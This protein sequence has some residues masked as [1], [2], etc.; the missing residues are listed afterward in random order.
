M[1]DWSLA[2]RNLLRNRR[3]TASTLAALA[4]GLLAILL[5]RGFETNLANTMYTTFVRGGGHMQIQHRDYYLFGSG[6]P[7]AYGIER[8]QE[9]LAAIRTDEQLQ[10]MVALA[11]PMLR[12]GGLAGNFDA[13]IARPVIGSGYVAGDVKVMREWN[14]FRVPLSRAE[15][16]LVGTPSDAAVIGVGVARVLQLCSSLRVADCPTPLA[17]QADPGGPLRKLPADIADLARIEGGSSAARTRTP[18][19]ELLTSSA[20]GAPN[21]AA[22]NVVAAEDQGIK[23]LDEISVILHLA[24]AQKLVFGRSAPRITAIIVLLKRS[25]DEDRAAA[26]L[27]ELLA[28]ESGR[29]SLVVRTFGELNPFYVQSD[30]MFNFIFGFFFLLIGG[31]VLF[32]VGNTINT[33]VVERTVEIGTLR[34]IGL[35][36]AGVRRQFVMEGFLMG[37]AGAAAGV[38]AAVIVAAAV[39]RWGLTWTPPGSSES[40]PL[41]LHVLGEPGLVAAVTIGLVGIATLSAW[42]PAWRAARLNIVEALRHA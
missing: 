7:T 33:A 9:L 34:A 37:G 42:W 11:T 17:E 12:F 19:L 4:V 10:S 24:Q 28:R 35:R 23:E 3:R 18:T 39:N 31:I 38:L 41:R 2:L 29:Q 30:R 14:E 8:Y 20:R 25:A 21:V 6:N 40:L 5:F 1:A 15:F 16:P 32:A 26:R 36:K 13:G 27:R 22:L